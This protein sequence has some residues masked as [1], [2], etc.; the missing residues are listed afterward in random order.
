MEQHLTE[1]I[2]SVTDE[3]R[4]SGCIEY[5]EHNL[6]EVSSTA[7]S[8]AEVSFPQSKKKSKD[9]SVPNNV[10]FRCTYLG[11]IASQYYLHYN[12]V[13]M[14]RT[15][16]LA[17][18]T[19]DFK[20]SV[21]ISSAPTADVSGVS[22]PPQAQKSEKKRS[23][24]SG[25][26][27]RGDTVQQ[28]QQQQQQERDVYLYRRQQLWEL[29]MLVC[30]VPEF[31]ELPVRHC[32]DELDEQLA[33]E[34]SDILDK[35]VP[36]ETG[37]RFDANSFYS[38]LQQRSSFDS[39]HAKAILLLLARMEGAPL[40]ISDY[41]TDT[42]TV[43]DQFTRVLKAMVDIASEEGLLGIVMRLQRLSQLVV[44]V[45]LGSYSVYT[46][47]RVRVSVFLSFACG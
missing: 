28:Q 14:I 39:P 11:R 1:L 34:L 10:S 13:G 38:F 29:L 40:P 5:D 43:L 27:T 20:H 22:A 42:K 44:Q 32:E 7:T 2:C 18:D 21:S 31:D 9:A 17:L 46:V 45:P 36:W 33:A 8:G 30:D 24:G 25:A 23:G 6:V 3:L 15:R 19:A 12:T 35:A 41:A 47:V 4:A 26:G 16:L 37:G